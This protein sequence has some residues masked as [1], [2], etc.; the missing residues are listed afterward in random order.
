MRTVRRNNPLRPG[1]MRR[2]ALAALASLSAA[3]ALQA[4]ELA[5]VFGD[6]MVLQRDQPITLRGTATP[7]EAV[8]ITLGGTVRSGEADD[9]GNWN[10]T[11]PA[12]PAGGP[13][14]L[15][16]R[17][18]DASVLSLLDVL[19]GDV[20]L[21]S[22]QSNMHF[23]ASAASGKGR[24][25]FDTRASI[26]LFTV[27]QHSH[28]APQ[29]GFEGR[30]EWRIADAESIPGFSAVCFF[31][32]LEL[33]KSNQ[34][35][36]GLIHSSWGGSQIQAWMSAG[37]LGKAG[38]YDEQ[39]AMLATYASD[40]RAGSAQFA[41]LWQ[42]WWERTVSAT[43]R[44]WEPTAKNPDGWS[45]IPGMQDWKTFG[46]ESLAGHNGSVWYRKTFELD[47]SEAKRD[48]HLHL[49]GIDEVDVT[50]INGTFVGSQFGWGTERTYEVPNGVLR[51][52]E[53][54]LVANVLSTWDSGGLL[55]P[56]EIVRLE[57][58][59]G[60]QHG[61]AEGWQYRKVS[62]EHG[63]PPR[64]P[65]ESIGGL[66][67]LF[68][69]MIAPL[70]GLRLTGALWYQGETNAGRPEPYAGLLGAM[71]ED[72][73]ERFGSLAFLVVQLPNFG[74]LLPRPSESGWAAIRD[75]QRRAALADPDTGLV[76]TIDAGDN[77]DL[78]PANKPVIG[79]RAAEVARAMLFGD[80]G[81]VDGLAPSHVR[82]S[83]EGVVLEFDPAVD[84]LVVIGDSRPVAFELCTD[85]PSG[86]E[87]AEA[88]LEGNRVVLSGPEGS[89]AT[90]VRHCWAD[91]PI[92][93]LYGK[94]GLPVGS[95][96]AT[97]EP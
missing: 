67:G 51:A 23:P 12:L 4:A 68:N 38:G 5:E 8:S 74:S 80:E 44:P 71:I 61:L 25:A 3:A 60:R 97:I 85:E 9:N 46:D 26:R 93:N 29:A 45:A 91:A 69:A 96:E 17:G 35:P 54:L 22:G 94:S 19:I 31:F 88:R 18:A 62:L 43:E 87:Y 48:A 64:A 47:Q 32:A 41:A 82:R 83:G 21:C 1:A 90:R 79:R 72:W 63:L 77:F 57:F 28:P 37:A 49:G 89:G 70:Q 92:C 36:I 73:R 10:I 55:G 15:V 58:E 65:W 78:H 66:S 14:E 53:N 59:D 86:C 81:V 33:Q 76:V 11:L 42:E 95:F 27:P 39:L 75:A 7:G 20:W 13:H 30:P 34:V 56:E 84:A 16:L 40:T 2:R 50:W 6:S 52:G 24:D